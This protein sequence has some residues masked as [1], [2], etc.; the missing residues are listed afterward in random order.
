MS[1]HTDRAYRKARQN[2]AASAI[3]YGTWQTLMSMSKRELAEI[4]IRLGSL[5]ADND[6]CDD[7]L[8][9]VGG[10]SALARVMEERDALKAN[11]LI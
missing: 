6:S 11:G 4:A 7:A 9:G 3:S 8:S 5:C 2:G 10:Q 1:I